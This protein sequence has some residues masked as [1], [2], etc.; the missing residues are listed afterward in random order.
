MV[1]SSGWIT[2]EVE[3]AVYGGFGYIENARVRE[4]VGWGYD[5]GKG[6]L[7][8]DAG[9]IGCLLLTVY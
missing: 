4:R 1:E 6:V 9:G 5:L 3:R 2:I 7:V 8:M